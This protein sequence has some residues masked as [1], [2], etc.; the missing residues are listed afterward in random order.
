M[1]LRKAGTP[2]LLVAAIL[3]PITASVAATPL[4]VGTFEVDATPPL[5]SPLAYDPLKEVVMP[6][7]CRGVVILGAEQPIV[8]CSIDWIGVG[9]EGYE[10]F[11][12]KLAEATDTTPEYV[13]VHA[14]HQH[15]APM[16][17]FSADR[18]LAEQGL[19]G[20]MFNVEHA[21]QVI[22]DAAESAAA[23][24]AEA[25]TVTHLGLGKA[26]VENVAS[27]RRI[28]GLDGRVSWTRYTAGASQLRNREAAPGLIDPAV[29]LIAFFHEDTPLA[30]LTYYATHPQSYYRTGGANPDFPGI[31][32]QMRQQATGAF[33]V[34][35]TG[36]GGNIGA[37]KWNDGSPAY[38]QILADRLAAGMAKA[39]ESM[40]RAEVQADDVGW[41]VEA[42]ALPLAEHLDPDALAARLADP[43]T[44]EKEKPGL[45]RNL[46]W[47][48]RCQA[49]DTIDLQCL[50]VGT[51]RVLHMP[52]ELFVE[53][54]LRAQVAGHELFVAMAAYGDYAPGYIGTE[55]SYAQGGYETSQRASRVGP[56]SEAVLAAAL[57]KLLAD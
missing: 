31:A 14:V 2:T 20:V 41:K 43:E 42:V 37:G 10:Q 49:G 12:R 4:K 53:Y 17:D 9:N 52:G 54:Q 30:V 46:A 8:L 56:G 13:A 5:G 50:R 34:H 36:A 35:F 44:P 33:H 25:Q 1:M 15:D 38:R 24:V 28:L 40:Q 57:S 29:K 6:L 22:R 16:C 48:R 39:W 11:R 27:N 23:A 3:L 21:Q 47:T 32:R 45:A 19:G 26:D 51:A 7:S 55:I 18:L